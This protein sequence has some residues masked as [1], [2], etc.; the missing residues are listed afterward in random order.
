MANEFMEIGIPEKITVTRDF[1]HL[2]IVRKWFGFR[3]IVLTLFVIV[4]D[5]FLL[6]WYAS[7]LSFP[8]LSGPGL[9]F[10]LFP[11]LHVAA[12]VGLTYYTLA[13]YL[14]RTTID[15]DFNSLTIRHG[16][17]PW[18]GNQDV[19]S[20]QLRQ[21]YSKRDDHGSSGYR[22]GYPAYSVHAITE[23]RRNLKLL[24]GLDTSEQALFIEQEIEKFLKI[25][26]KP[27]KGAIR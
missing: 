15:V 12:G 1:Q 19:S 11:L 24:S 13:G 21:L 20:R 26:D 25:E 4:W 8:S 23:E 16:P 17:L 9:M 14:N 5:A 6:N 18:W 22:R 27:V 3:F 10:A 2:Q 7:I